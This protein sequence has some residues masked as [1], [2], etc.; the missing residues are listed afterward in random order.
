MKILII[1][2]IVVLCFISFR[3][4]IIIGCFSE[5]Y[6]IKKKSRVRNASS[7]FNGECYTSTFILLFTF[8][9]QYINIGR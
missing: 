1:R 9:L 2:S 4:L 7:G 8:I 6:T 3:I 5:Y